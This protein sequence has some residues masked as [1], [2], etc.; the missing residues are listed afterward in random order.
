MDT[1][2]NH[3][4][5]ERPAKKKLSEVPLFF[6][7]AHQPIPKLIASEA[8]IT[9]QSNPSIMGLS[10]SASGKKV[11]IYFAM[12]IIS[13]SREKPGKAESSYPLVLTLKIAPPAA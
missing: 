11:E 7:A 6:L 8:A 10:L 2:S 5:M 13:S 4:G 3:H 1:P 12:S 9:I